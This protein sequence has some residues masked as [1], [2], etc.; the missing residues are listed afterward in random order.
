MNVYLAD[1]S[2]KVREG[3][4]SA[5]KVLYSYLDLYGVIDYEKGLDKLQVQTLKD[6]LKGG[7][8]R[9]NLWS[10][11]LDTNRSNNTIRNYLAVYRDFL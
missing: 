2:Y 5:L 1:S 4:F 11:E 9:G 8:K 10:L 6:F 7:K 3:A